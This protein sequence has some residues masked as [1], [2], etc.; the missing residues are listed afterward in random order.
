MSKREISIKR[1]V[2]LAEAITYIQDL[3]GSLREGKVFVQQGEEYVT[4]LPRE[5]VALE[6]KVRAKKDREKFSFSIDWYTECE[7]CEGED[8]K[9]SAEQPEGHASEDEAAQVTLKPRRAACK[10]RK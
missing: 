1:S 10:Q 2:E 5:K 4:L 3:A 6:I 7:I 9:I 8:I